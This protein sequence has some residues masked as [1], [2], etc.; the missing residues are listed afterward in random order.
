MYNS[1]CNVTELKIKATL[2]RIT[3]VPS[4]DS[5][6]NTK[7]SYMIRTYDEITRSNWN[8]NIINE[9]CPVYHVCDFGISG[10][11]DRLEHYIF[12]VNVAKLFEATLLMKAHFDE[13]VHKEFVEYRNIMV[14][15]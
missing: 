14:K 6:N 13:G 5:Y 7:S 10:L 1:Q 2:A 12:C 3:P 9:T 15:I 4:F 11:G 8:M